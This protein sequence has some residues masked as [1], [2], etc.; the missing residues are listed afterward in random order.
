MKCS[1]MALA[2]SLKSIVS[3]WRKFEGYNIICDNRT[4]I[5]HIRGLYSSSILFL[6]S[7]ES[8]FEQYKHLG[9]IMNIWI[10]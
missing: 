5:L 1:W 3:G 8:E 9:I 10:L 2:T 4:G 7:I 6:L